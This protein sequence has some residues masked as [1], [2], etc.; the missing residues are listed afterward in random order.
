VEPIEDWQVF[1][2]DEEFNASGQPWLSADEPV[3]LE[4]ENHLMDRGRADA[5][6]A[7]HVGFGWSLVE[8]VRIDVDEGQIVALLFGEAVRAAPARGA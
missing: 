3:A 2:W 7:L 1:W 5:E 8:D 6:V 4:A